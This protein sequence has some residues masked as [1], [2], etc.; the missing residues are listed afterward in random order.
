M[1]EQENEQEQEKGLGSQVTDI[2]KKVAKDAAKN[3]AKKAGKEVAKK[4]ITKAILPALPYIIIVIL[5]I[6]ALVVIIDKIQEIGKNISTSIATIMEIGDNGP[7]APSAEEIFRIIEEKLEENQID[8]EELGLGNRLQAKLYLYKFMS[9]A[10]STELPYIKES[11]A[12]LIKEIATHI[13]VGDIA[14]DIGHK[15]EVQGIVK[16]KRRTDD[17][18]KDLE[19][20]KHEDFIKLIEENNEKNELTALNYFS[21]DEDWMLCIAKYNKTTITKPN[22]EA[23]SKMSEETKYI[24]EE[25]KIP[26]QTMVSKYSVPF[27]FFIALQQMSGN[28]EYVSAVA[29][30]IQEDSEIE[31]TIFDTKQIIT[32]EYT[33]TYKVK[34]KWLEEVSAEKK[35]HTPP[36]T[37]DVPGTKDT[38]ITSRASN[39]RRIAAKTGSLETIDPGASDT[40]SSEAI[41]KPVTPIPDK[42][43]GADNEEKTDDK[44]EKEEEEQKTETKWEEKDKTGEEKS[45]TTTTITEINSI[46]ASITKAN[47]WVVD[48]KNEYKKSTEEPVYPLGKDGYTESLEAENHK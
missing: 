4:A 46:T 45:E 44:E 18:V 32:N 19:F 6:V 7:V 30:L 38:Y 9:A 17:K 14:W 2:G 26:Y 10:L 39:I 36:E 20:K 33:Y 22:N 34:E 5:A 1:E 11:K 25:Q 48:Y 13:L 42:P 3:T 16:I 31:L 35:P 12:P 37:I 15:Q 40:S 21:I 27:E 24:V 47:V 43:E 23:E 29:D 8:I 41:T 28:P